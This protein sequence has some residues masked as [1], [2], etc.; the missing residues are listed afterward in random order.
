LKQ[1]PLTRPQ[2]SGDR[3]RIIF[4]LIL[5]ASSLDAIDYLIVIKSAL[6]TIFWLVSIAE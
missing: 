5:T 6:S 1:E 2:Q 3:S 4:V